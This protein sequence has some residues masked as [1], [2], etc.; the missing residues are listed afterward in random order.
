M[1]SVLIV[2]NTHT[3]MEIISGMLSSGM[4]SR[5]VT[6]QNGA[7]GRRDL[8]DDEFDLIIIDTPLPDELGDDLSL[9]AA[10]T[11]AAGIILIV[12][13]EV[14]ADIDTSVEDAGV[15]V[16]PKPVSP[17][18]FYQ[19]VK[20]L[21]ASRRRVMKLESENLQL[22]KKISEIRLVDRAKCILIQYL[23]MTE[24]QAH[25]YIEKQSMDLRQSRVVTA[26]NILKTYES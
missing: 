14:L 19:A 24:V 12:R 10:E 25:R 9:Y 16:L 7:E 26:Q 15:F 2:S 17:E 1:D 22:Q 3:T 20:L 11:S 5:I 23:N 8:I 4:F 21:T 13:Q 6:A 18:F